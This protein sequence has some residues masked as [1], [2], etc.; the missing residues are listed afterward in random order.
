MYALP[1][2]QAETVKPLIEERFNTYIET[3]RLG[4]VNDGKEFI[5]WSERDG[6]AHFYLYDENGKLKNQITSGTYHVENILAIDDAKR[7]LYF[8]ANGKES[9]E[10]PYYLHAYKVN[11]DGSG[12][13]LL[14]P[15][16]FEHAMNMNDGKNFFVDNYSRVN[17]TPK[18]TFT[19]MSAN[20][21]SSAIMHSITFSILLE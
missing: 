1:M 10:D 7:V 6:Y 17:A 2:W 18:S 12:L 14:N 11:F 19:P 13:K 16:E 20:T 21:V 3:R 5:Q 9:G 15:G 8:S 4:L